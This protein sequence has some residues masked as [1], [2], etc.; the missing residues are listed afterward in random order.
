[1]PTL[2]HHVTPEVSWSD[3]AYYRKKVA[4]Y[5]EQYSPLVRKH[6]G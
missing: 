6:S 5:C 1:V 2:D 3:F 4:E